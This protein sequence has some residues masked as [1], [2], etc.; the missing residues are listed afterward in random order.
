M[1]S[2]LKRA[3]KELRLQDAREVLAFPDGPA[4]LLID[5]AWKI[6][7]HT[8]YAARLGQA[9]MSC[10]CYSSTEKRHIPVLAGIATS[11][12]RQQFKP[13]GLLELPL[14]PL[15][16]HMAAA[17]LDSI[18]QTWRAWTKWRTNAELRTVLLSVQANPRH[19]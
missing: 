13:P 3:S 7:P 2:T 1:P 16:D 6:E 10:S 17:V 9:L 15:E 18:G 14:E 11:W 19:L 8:E 12:L 5:E 4:L